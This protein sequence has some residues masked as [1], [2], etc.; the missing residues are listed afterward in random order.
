MRPAPRELVESE[1]R[2]LA[3]KIDSSDSNELRN[4]LNNGPFKVK[5]SVITD[6]GVI[7][8]NNFIQEIKLQWL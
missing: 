7:Q 5:A 8:L 6:R 1:G 4:G 3:K 2:F